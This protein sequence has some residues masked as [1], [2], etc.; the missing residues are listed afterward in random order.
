MLSSMLITRQKIR[1]GNS[2]KHIFSVGCTKKGALWGQNQGFC[3]AIFSQLCRRIFFVPIAG[4][5]K[6]SENGFA[7]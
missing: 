5:E 6:G 2:F 7:V 4:Q 3:S 1:F